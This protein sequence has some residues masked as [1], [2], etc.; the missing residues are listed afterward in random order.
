MKLSNLKGLREDNDKTQKDMADIL[1]VK[2]GTY[3]SWECGSD[4]IPIEHLYKIANYYNASIDYIL[5]ISSKNEKLNNNKTID[6][7]KVG[8]KLKLIRK[9][10]NL[11]QMKFAN[12]IGINQS[13]WWAYENS[14]NMITTST[15]HEISRKYNYSIDWILD[16]SKN[17]YVSVEKR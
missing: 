17:K 3:A 2:R 5:N 12:S 16:R 9:E 1:N 13:T 10:Q 8:E 6:K 7:I 15:L 4:I 11:T 14:V